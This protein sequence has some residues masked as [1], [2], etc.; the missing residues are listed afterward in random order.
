MSS[1]PL[2]HQE[3]GRRPSLPS[4][5]TTFE[6]KRIASV[7]Y[8]AEPTQ[9]F[10]M[11]A[12]GSANKTTSFLIETSAGATIATIAGEQMGDTT[13]QETGGLA[14]KRPSSLASIATK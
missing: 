4:P 12:T 3:P 2:R 7:V 1:I 9:Q 5:S 10:R 6:N 11:Q 14:D 8:I 13:L